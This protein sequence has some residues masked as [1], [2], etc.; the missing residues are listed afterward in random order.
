MDI[1][2]PPATEITDYIVRVRHTSNKKN[3]ISCP[4]LEAKTQVD[5]EAYY[6]DTKHPIIFWLL[7]QVW[8]A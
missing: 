1:V 8:T 7:T 2:V 4:F 3:Y 6:K 5:I